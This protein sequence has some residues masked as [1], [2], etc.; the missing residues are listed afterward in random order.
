MNPLET[1]Q[2]IYDFA[3][4][5]YP[6]L[7]NWP[8]AEKFALTNRIKNCI[9]TMLEECVALRKSSTKKSHAYAI[10][11]ELDMLRT[12]F[13]LGYDLKYCNAH[14]YEVIGRKLAEIGGRVG[15]LIKAINTRSQPWAEPLFS[16]H[17]L[18]AGGNWNNGAHCGARTVN[19]NNYPWNVN[20]YVG[21]RGACDFY[22]YAGQIGTVKALPTDFSRSQRIR[23]VRGNTRQTSKRTAAASSPCKRGSRVAL[24]GTNASITFTI[25]FTP[26]KIC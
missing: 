25:K 26:M 6:I 20:T 15:G 13:H 19:C 1:E 18:I 23:P 5:I 17:A 16:L 2:L 24:W 21:V 4:Y 11:R 3:L 10:D 7:N 9:F 8:K 12:Y 14:R 22:Y